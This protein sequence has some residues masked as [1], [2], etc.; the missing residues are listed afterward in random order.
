[1]LSYLKKYL[2]YLLPIVL[3]GVLIY[4]VY[5]DFS[6]DQL[7]EALSE[8]NGTLVLVSLVPLFL[9]HF[10]RAMR[11]QMLLKP[12]GYEPP[13]KMLFAAVMAG[14][15][16]NLVLP[17]SGEVLR[18][19][20]LQRNEG[21]PVEV[22]LGN[23]LAERVMDLIS[24]ALL[25][26]LAL[27]VEYERLGNFLNELIIQKLA[28]VNIGPGTIFTFLLGA[29]AMGGLVVFVFWRMKNHPIVA[30]IWAFAVK[31]WGGLVSVKDVENVPLFLLLS[32]LIWLGYLVSSWLVIMAFL[33]TA[34]LPGLSTLVLNVLGGFAMIAPTQGGLG[35]YHFMVSTGLSSI[36]G[37]DGNDTRVLAFL[38]H[39][40]QYIA[41][42]IIGGVIALWLMNRK[43]STAGAATPN[44]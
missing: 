10:F 40:S 23:V 41:T 19:S 24:L 18:P 17:R 5:K 21:V 25:T 37:I 28:G 38:L 30:P 3:A 13:L 8:T 44:P 2:A 39:T 36:Y 26:M 6:V 42:L 35:A 7:K 34:S 12:L 33:P 32:G 4:I 22:S 11:W 20:L 1:M 29:A 14:Y 27:L 31:L 43:P 15:A 9:S 16:A